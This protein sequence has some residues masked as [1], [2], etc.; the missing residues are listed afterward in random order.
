M[1]TQAFTYNPGQDST[2]ATTNVPLVKTET[3]TVTYE[4]E[5][6]GADDLDPGYLVSA[7]S[8]SSKTHTVET[9]T[10][11]LRADHSPV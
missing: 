6:H 7:Q 9:T 8:H 4:N 5:G 1:A 3:R 2:R 10:V 11:S